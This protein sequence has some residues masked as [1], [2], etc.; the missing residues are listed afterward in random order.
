VRKSQ[1]RGPSKS[2]R[3]LSRK[4]E[5]ESI[6]R[7]SA[8]RLIKKGKKIKTML[9]VLNLGVFFRGER[10]AKLTA[11]EEKRVPS[12]GKISRHLRTRESILNSLIGLGSAFRSPSR[13][14]EKKGRGD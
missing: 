6:K 10:H 11:Q 12:N 13:A 9:I 1:D 3:V 4:K 14:K 7:L 2:H 8:H 5:E